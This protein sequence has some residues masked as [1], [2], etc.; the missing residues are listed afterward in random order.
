[1]SH[2]RKSLGDSWRVILCGGAKLNPGLYQFYL[3][4]GFPIFEGWG[5]TEASTT[6]VNTP[7]H[8]QVGTVGPPLPGVKVKLGENDELLLGGP[9]VMRGYYR[10]PDATEAVIDKEGWLHTG[11]KGVIDEKGFVKIVGRV[12]EQFKLSTGEYVVPGKIEHA[13]S[14]HYLIDAAM[15]IGESKKYPAC[16]F[17]LDRY[18]LKRVRREHNMP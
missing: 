3:N 6:C 5:L 9:T 14:Q 12:K 11:D 8:L 2:L 1:Y 10:N 17:V 15:V 7:E 4:I 18:G 13:L 16:I